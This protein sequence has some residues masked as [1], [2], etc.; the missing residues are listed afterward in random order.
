MEGA[1]ILIGTDGIA[2]GG[3]NLIGSGIDILLVSALFITSAS[4]VSCSTS[5]G[6]FCIRMTCFSCSRFY[7]L[8][9]YLSLT[10]RDFSMVSGWILY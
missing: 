9:L 7:W 2:G 10:R 4:S 6:T 3:L 1:A 5:G 8:T